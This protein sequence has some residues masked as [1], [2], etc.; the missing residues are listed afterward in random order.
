MNEKSERVEWRN[1]AI[2]KKSIF[3]V[4]IMTKDD[5]KQ[6]L[7]DNGYGG[8][9]VFLA[10]E[11]PASIDMDDLRNLLE[12]IGERH[13]QYEDWDFD[14]ICNLENMGETK[15]FIDAFNRLARENMSYNS[16]ERVDIFH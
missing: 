14:M 1:A 9:Y 2:C 6:K 12:R 4:D 7:K 10:L 5:L 16:G 15:A 3:D 11:N 8:M 13:E